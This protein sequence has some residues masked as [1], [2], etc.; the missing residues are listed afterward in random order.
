MDATGKYYW[1]SILSNGVLPDD[2]VLFPYKA[3]LTKLAKLAYDYH[4]KTV[5]QNFTSFGEED[6]V[7]AIEEYIA[8]VKTF[9]GK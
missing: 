4:F 8:V 9:L 3:L 5:Q 6:E 7:R 1:M 2:S